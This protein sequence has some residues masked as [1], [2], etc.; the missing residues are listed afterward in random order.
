MYHSTLDIKYK[1]WCL[2]HEYDL[3]E[4]YSIFINI[5]SS[6]Y[7]NNIKLNRTVYEKFCKLIYKNST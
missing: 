6:R 2:L 7:T 5:L 4:L 3:K 1:N